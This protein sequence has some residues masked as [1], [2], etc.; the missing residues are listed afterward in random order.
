MSETQLRYDDRVEQMMETIND[1][2]GVLL[3]EGVKAHP[4]AVGALRIHRVDGDELRQSQAYGAAKRHA[5][6]GLGVESEQLGEH[7]VEVRVY[8]NPT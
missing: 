8:Q 7:T 3:C 5:P 4:P 1:G 2:S 6:D